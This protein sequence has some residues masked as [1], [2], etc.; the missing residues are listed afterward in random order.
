MDH[1]AVNLLMRQNRALHTLHRAR[2]GCDGSVVAIV[3]E[4]SE[5][6]AGVLLDA[7]LTVQMRLHDLPEVLHH[8]QVSHFRLGCQM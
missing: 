8:A 6:S 5:R 1:H 7:C 2:P 3:K 4:L